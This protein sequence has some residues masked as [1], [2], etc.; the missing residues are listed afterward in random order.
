V[1]ELSLVLGGHDHENWVLR[2]GPGLTPIVKADANVR[3]VALVRMTFAGDGAP[4]I[5]ADFEAITDATAADSR[6]DAEVGRW[7]RLA[8]DAFRAEGFEPD[9]VVA[10]L[11]ESLDGRESTVRNFEGNLT[12]LISEALAR[13]AG[14]VDVALMNGGSVRIDDQLLPGLLSEYD[15]IRVLPFGGQVVTA[16]MAGSLLTRV[17]DVGQQNRGN[18]GFLHIWGASRESGRWVIDGRAIVPG[19]KYRVA[20]TDWLMTGRETNLP[21]LTADHPLISDVSTHQ[22]IRQ[23][24]ITELQRRYPSSGE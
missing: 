6:V 8:Y 5:D 23:A 21:F 3:S 12:D 22:D 9:K 4:T 11:T 19:A 1:P 13:A 17:L 24:V 16:T 15:V 10:R 7:T 20:L 14:S 18:G 2:R